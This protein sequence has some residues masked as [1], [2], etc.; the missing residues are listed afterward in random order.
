MQLRTKIFCS[1]AALAVMS[2]ATFFMTQHY[3]ASMTGDSAA[4]NLAG[5]QRMLI[6]KMGKELLLEQLNPGPETRRAVL[7]SAAVFEKTMEALYAGG[8]APQ[9]LALD[10]PQLMLKPAYGTY[11][12]AMEDVQGPLGE[13]M[14]LA[15]KAADGESTAITAY[16]EATGKGLQLVNTIVEAI[17]YESEKTIW[18]L[19]Y[20]QL[21]AMLVS[22]VIFCIVAYMFQVSFLRNL[23]KLLQYSHSAFTVLPGGE[24]QR[25]HGETLSIKGKDEMATLG[26]ALE[27]LVFS[28]DESLE[29]IRKETERVREESAK[30]H[31]ASEQAEEGMRAAETKQR[32]LL[33]IADELEL[34]VVALS[35]ASERL[36]G[37]LQQVEKT[38]AQQASRMKETAFS[39]QGMNAA[40]LDV[41]HNAAEASHMAA[42]SRD[43]A[44][45]GTSVV[46]QTLGSIRHVKEESD[47]LKTSM[48]ALGEQAEAIKAVMGVISDIA[49]QTNLLALN[50]AIEAA[51]AGEAGKGFAVVADEVRKL[52]EKTMHSTGEVGGTVRTIHDSVQGN[53][54][55]V[56][57][58]VEQIAQAAELAQNSGDALAA[59]AGMIESSSD[60]VQAIAAAAEEQSASSEE[61]NHSISEVHN[62]AV[63]TAEV[64]QESVEAVEEL[65]RQTQTIRTLIEQ[66]KVG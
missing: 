17:Q 3:T 29:N 26:Q 54:R 12:T 15:R 16:I 10:G 38:V 45:M 51:R 40:V 4:M 18:A 37:R 8:P 53:I 32:N 64:V 19:R 47:S 59:I 27:K 33:R 63:S 25:N 31:L 48:L 62:L 23:K 30:A 7:D 14:V 41:A 56:D 50:A 13:L 57:S 36:F 58:T 43:T 24:L 11:R 39:M 20:N 21:G 42:Q 6:Q 60:Q 65:T 1:L 49:D 5:R 61:I 9:T 22:L 55:R 2:L 46:E 66:M 52:A 28:L 35:K 44:R 34:V